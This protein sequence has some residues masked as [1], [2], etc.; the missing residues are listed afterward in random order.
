MAKITKEFK[1]W[2]E[3]F[4]DRCW[5]NDN[6]DKP[7]LI[8]LLWKVRNHG[9]KKGFKNGYEK[10]HKDIYYPTRKQK[11]YEQTVWTRNLME[12][13]VPKETR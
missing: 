5:P 1:E 4:Y 2:F 6:N 8:K 10:A 3:D 12:E 13:L 7:L 11:E 9:Y